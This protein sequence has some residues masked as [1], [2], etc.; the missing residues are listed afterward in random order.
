[1]K[2][3]HASVVL[4]TSAVVFAGFIS[5]LPQEPSSRVDDLVR[6]SHFIFAG[7]VLKTSTV[8]LK[9]LSPGETTAL[10]RAD[11]LLDAP[12]SLVG[13]KG[14]VV[15]LELIRPGEAKADDTAVYFTNGILFGDPLEVKEVGRMPLPADTADLR[16][17][18]SAVR[19]RAEEEKVQ[20]RA[21]RALRIATGKGLEIMPPE[22]TRPTN[23]HE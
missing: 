22:K 7:R 6:A 12:P 9:V 23:E 15:T 8:N 21:N 3:L 14:Q 17:Q 16:R 13:I 4:L 11:E 1:M 19:V 18:I 10:V 20:A 2:P 5:A